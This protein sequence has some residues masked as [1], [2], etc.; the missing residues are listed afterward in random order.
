MIYSNVK[1]EVKS[2]DLGC[3]VKYYIGI[4]DTHRPVAL[5]TE[6]N[7]ALEKG[8]NHKITAGINYRRRPCL[9]KQE[10]YNLYL[11]LYAA[12]NDI[13]TETGEIKIFK[14][15]AD[16]VRV[17]SHFGQNKC[18]LAEV[19]DPLVG[20]LIQVRPYGLKENAPADLYIIHECNVYHCKSDTL[21][22]C[23][24]EHNIEW[25]DGFNPRGLDLIAVTD[26]ITM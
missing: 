5:W 4:A 6:E 9:L 25:A 10:D 2:K 22:E 19:V 16:N 14:Q 1:T 23:C 21:E 17:I 15:H 12:T 7:L 13:G 3:G 20:A 8:M 24:K 18:L 11:F 26:W